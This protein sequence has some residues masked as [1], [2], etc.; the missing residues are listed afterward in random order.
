MKLWKKTSTIYFHAFFNAIADGVLNIFLPIIIYQQTGNLYFAVGFLAVQ[1]AVTGLINIPIRRFLA[2]HG[3]MSL[4]LHVLFI[5]IAQALIVLADITILTVLLSGIFIGLS[6]AFYNATVF[7]HM[8][9][10]DKTFNVARQNSWAAVGRAVFIMLGAYLL[11]NFL[12]SSFPLALTVASF[13]YIISI[14]PLWKDFKRGGKNFSVG[15]T[16]TSTV[17]NEALVRAHFYHIF[18]GVCHAVIRFLI[19]LYLVVRGNDIITIGAVMAITELSA[20]AASYI[21]KTLIFRRGFHVALFIIAILFTPCFIGLIFV[22]G[23][24]PT[25]IL[26][27]I[28]SFAL[29]MLYVA[30]FSIYSRRVAAAGCFYDG[31]CQR[32]FYI[33]IGRFG[34]VGIFLVVPLF[35]V[36][37]VIGALNT[38]GLLG[39]QLRR[40]GPR[41]IPEMPASFS[42]DTNK[43]NLTET[44]EE[45]DA[46][47]QSY[48]QI[49]V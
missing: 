21:S 5:I 44:D 16:A 34:L 3:M 4:Y 48:E 24:I 45:A 15:G 13:L 14:V 11:G 10:T 27:S 18:L 12:Q 30:V 47:E 22:S 37:L 9:Y 36:I 46:K 20:V 33:S 29:N 19:P 35:P 17:V 31:I 42:A 26:A 7:F 2:K 41:P 40:G 6:V 8:A 38:A 1:F 32:E 28:L 39:T 23:A 25:F 43:T 49:P